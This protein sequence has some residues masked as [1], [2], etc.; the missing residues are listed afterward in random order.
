[1]TAPTVVA[2]YHGTCVEC[3]DPIVPGQRITP[4]DE[5][6]MHIDCGELPEK[7]IC[8]CEKCFTVHAGACL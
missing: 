8:A 7:A 5:G 2:E 1:M 3:D 6:W 4:S